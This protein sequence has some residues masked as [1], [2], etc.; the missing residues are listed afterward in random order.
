MFLKT[1][2]GDHWPE[3]AEKIRAWIKETVG[4]AARQLA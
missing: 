2:V 4:Q 1:R 3:E